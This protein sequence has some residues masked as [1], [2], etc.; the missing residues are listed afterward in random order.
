MLSE[1]GV[2]LEFEGGGQPQA[3]FQQ[4][5]YELKSQRELR[6]SSLIL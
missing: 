1:G 4:D 6:S 2:E 5:F 3:R